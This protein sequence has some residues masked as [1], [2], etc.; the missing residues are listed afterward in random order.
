MSPQIPV[1]ASAVAGKARQVIARVRPG[2][3]EAHRSLPIRSTPDELRRLWA[4][5]DARTVVLEGIPVA[6]AELDFGPE[7]P[8]WG[9]TVGLQL[10]VDAPVPGMATAILAGK[11]LRRLKAMAETGEAPTTAKNPSARPDAEGGA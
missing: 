2:A 8:G 1:D 4:D 11:A 7:V 10:K 5:A 3:T 6:D 9:A